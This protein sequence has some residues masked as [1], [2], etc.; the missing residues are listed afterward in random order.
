MFT[1][2]FKNE[3]DENSLNNASEIYE[4]LDG[5]NLCLINQGVQPKR[6][7]LKKDLSKAK[8]EEILQHAR[9]LIMQAKKDSGGILVLN[10]KLGAIQTFLSFGGYF[11]ILDTMYHNRREKNKDAVAKNSKQKSG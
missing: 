1:N 10:Q 8:K 5:Y 11:S 9:Y 7:S 2:L 6:F 3:E 4:I